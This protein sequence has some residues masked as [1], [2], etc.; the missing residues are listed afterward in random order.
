MKQRAKAFFLDFIILLLA[1]CASAFAVTGIMLPNGLTSGGITGIARIL[2]KFM[3]VDFSILYYGLSLIVLALVALFLGWKEVK[4]VLLLSLL[5][6]AVLFL[7]EQLPIQLLEKPDILLAA[8]F[9]GVFT[10][11]YVGLVFWR[12]YASAG[13]DA[14]AKI[15][16]KKL[17]S[18]VSLA[19]LLM[20]IDGIIIIASAF[21]Y[22]RNIALY[23]LVTQMIITKMSELIM[24]G[25]EDKIV[26]LTIIT[27]KSEEIR[28]Y[29]IH[30]LDRSL[31]IFAARGGYTNQDMRQLVLLCSPRE[32]LRLKKKLA[33]IDPRAFVVVTKAETV[34]G[35]GRNFEDIGEEQQ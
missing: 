12:G 23:A 30:D 25:F 10:G 28:D 1:C 17:F 7:F 15:F 14:I 3:D 8:I 24:Y 5:Y 16:K 27:S 22:G 4:R 31:S 19:K 33:E 29:I 2:Q 35:A 34:W 13:S 18:Q 11:V 20:C 26:Q 6:P 9:S 32:S 21:T